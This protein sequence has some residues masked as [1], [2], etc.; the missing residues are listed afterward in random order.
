MLERMWRKGNPLTLLVAQMVKNLPVV[1]ETRVWSQ[2]SIS[3][4]RE[5]Q[6]TPVLLPGEFH[7]QRTWR[8]TV[9]GI[10]ESDTTVRLTFRF[11]SAM[12]CFAAGGYSV[13][14]RVCNSIPDFC[15]GPSSSSPL[16]PTHQL[17]ATKIV[18]RHC[19]VLGRVG[20]WGLWDANS[21]P[22]WLGTTD[23]RNDQC[24]V[25]S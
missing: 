25:K 12:W 5:W 17:L 22:F 8:V 10:A 14:Y 4:R 13:P 24:C 11:L 1:W 15:P 3:W 9:H 7:G 2:G 21:F 18:F 19:D 6:P 16:H 23:M 20:E